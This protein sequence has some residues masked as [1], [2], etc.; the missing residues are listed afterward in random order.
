[1]YRNLLHQTSI[2]YGEVQ[3]YPVQADPPNRPYTANPAQVYRALLHQTSITYWKMR[4]PSPLIE[5][6]CTESY[7]TKPVDSIET[8][9]HT[10]CRWTPQSSP[11]V[12]SP[13]T[14]KRPS[15]TNQAQVYRDLLHQTNI[16]Y[17]DMRRPSPTN[18]PQVYRA[19]LHQTSRTYWEMR[20]YP[21]QMDPP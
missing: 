16:I 7:Y 6:K 3:T 17:W 10:Q 5:P 20:P 19:L 21:V 2:T 14:P 8:Y 11:S 12:E 1:M 15:P 4:R 9:A 18:W 13:T